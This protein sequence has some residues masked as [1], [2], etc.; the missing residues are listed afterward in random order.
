MKAHP[1]TEFLALAEAALGEPLDEQTA[2]GLLL[3]Q[4]QLRV[5][6]DEMATLLRSGAMSRETYLKQNNIALRDAMKASEALLGRDRF[7]AIFGEA[8]DYPEGL[9]DGDAFLAQGSGNRDPR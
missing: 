8:G 5:R 7:L 6:T 4:T 9:I 2:C 3:I 1:L